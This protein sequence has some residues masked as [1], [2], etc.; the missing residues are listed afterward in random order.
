MTSASHRPAVVLCGPP[1]AGKTTV[2][3]L[4]ARA[5]GV[6]FIDTDREVERVAGLP[7]PQMFL[8]QGEPAFRELEHETVT[9]LLDGFDGI[10]ALGG[11]AVLDPRTQ[12]ALREHMVVFLD[13][14]VEQ[15]LPRVG[16]SGVRP[17]LM[18][19]PV[20]KFHNL[21]KERR[22][23]YE[24]VSTLTVDTT[25]RRPQSVGEEILLELLARGAAYIDPTSVHRAASVYA[26]PTAIEV[27]GDDGYDVLVGWD[28]VDSV[29]EMV[30]EDSGR[31]LVLHPPVVAE[32]AERVRSALEQA[33]KSATSHLLPE[34]EA[35]KTF[36]VATEMWDL[37]GSLRLGRDDTIVAV[38][39]GATTDLAGFVAACWLRGVRLVNVPST[40]LAMVD[41]SVGG[42]TGINISDG[43]NLVGAFY[44]PA[45]VVCDLRLLETLPEA[46][47]RAGLAEV[48]KCGFISDEQILRLVEAD[49][50]AGALDRGSAVMR[51]LIERAVAVK[52]RV[53][54]EDLKEIGL[55]EILNYGHTFGHAIEAV[56]NF[57]VRHGEAVAVGLVFAAELSAR[58]GQLDPTAVS[59][60]RRVLAS[61]GLGSTYDAGRWP[62][63]LEAMGHD[64][65]RRRDVLR[66][67]VLDEVGA[68]TILRDPA[69]GVLADCYAAVS[70]V[71]GP[72]A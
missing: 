25:G 32:Y 65:K 21:M 8:E 28:L 17:L 11:G 33:G 1:G 62:E 19:D 46:D 14:D 41:A 47:Y 38:G 49:G 35:C 64:K 51:E 54:G 59:R 55:R 4:I 27:A 3:T 10:L 67:V 5:L 16:L 7:I 29:V 71:A 40:L 42:K 9:R 6:E 12:E 68:P 48:V 57:T 31:V 53:V 69:P 56:E 66:F 15:A 45:G 72:A 60:H 50:G 24:A 70:T 58:A 20:G 63:L 2:G 52:A 34:G 37:L 23:I 36:A 26:P 43:K 30:G 22:P 39:G 13:V 18:G 44:P 61:V